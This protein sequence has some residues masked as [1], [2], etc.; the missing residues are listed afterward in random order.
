MF[1]KGN[2]VRM[3]YVIVSRNV[4]VFVNGNNERVLGPSWTRHVPSWVTPKHLVHQG[5]IAFGP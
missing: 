1:S 4:V 3:L 5:P 2:G